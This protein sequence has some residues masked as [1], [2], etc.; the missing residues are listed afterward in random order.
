MNLD[1]PDLTPVK[2]VIYLDNDV[3]TVL[4]AFTVHPTIQRIQRFLSCLQEFIWSQT[5]LAKFSPLSEDLSE[6]QCNL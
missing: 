3:D 2:Q 6:D 1:K 5:P 4:M